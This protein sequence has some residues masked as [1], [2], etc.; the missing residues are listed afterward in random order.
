[1]F[2]IK[3]KDL[4]WTRWNLAQNELLG[5]K[6]AVIGGTNGLGRAIAKS[7]ASKGAEVIV[8]G[9]TF[10]DQGILIIGYVIYDAMYFCRKKTIK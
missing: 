4:T 9:R 3:R 10:R 7:L 8:I 2:G 1:M 5:K 6:V